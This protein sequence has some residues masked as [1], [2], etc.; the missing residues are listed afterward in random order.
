MKTVLWWGRFDPEYSRNR[1]LRRAFEAL[2]WCCRPFHPRLSRIG[3]WEAA[4]RRIEPPEVVWVPCFRQ[5]DVPAARRW[6]D[7]HRLPMVFD[8]LIS[9]YDK[10]VY[11]R[12][13]F[14]AASRRARNLLH[15]EQSLF[16]AADRLVADTGE[17][18]TFFAECLGA[19]PERTHV[20]PV[21]AEESLFFA[22]SP[23]RPARDEL[24]VLFFGSFLGLQGPQVI[25]EAARRYQG[26]PVRWCLIGEGPLRPACEAAAHGLSSVRF[27]NWIPYA[28]LP[29]RIRQADVLLGIFGESAKASRVIPNKVFQA[30]ACGKPLITRAS[31]AYPVGM[32]TSAMSG[33]H[34]VPAADPDALAAAVAKLAAEPGQLAAMGRASRLTYEAHFSETA[35]REKLQNLLASLGL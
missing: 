2:G 12:E 30:L 10:Q 34:W 18:A 23:P 28:Q 11:E 8:P 21:G 7:R 29:E 3:D 33:V 14:A 22:A 9:S 17:H 35:V 4:W 19:S 5:R 16:R 13:K 6:S 24:E 20:I 27:E 15:A 26:P 1:V 25:V 32:R 31:A